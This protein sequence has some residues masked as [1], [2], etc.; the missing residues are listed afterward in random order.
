MHAGI[1]LTGSTTKNNLP[2]EEIP[3]SNNSQSNGSRQT[4][5]GSESSKFNECFFKPVKDKATGKE[6]WV[7][8]KSVTKYFYIVKKEVIGHITYLENK[9]TDFYEN[10]VMKR[11]R[12]KLV[13]KI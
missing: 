2:S 9:E 11:K 8:D 1:N 7:L 6:T 13:V 4:W 5:E 3:L 10:N 12:P